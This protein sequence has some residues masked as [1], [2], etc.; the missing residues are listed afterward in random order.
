MTLSAAAREYLLAFADDE[1]LIGAR[2]TNW[3]GLGPFLEEDLAFCS[4]AQ[5][6]LGHAVALYGLLLDD[7]AQLDAFAMIRDPVRLP[8]LLA[9]R[10]RMPRLE[11]LARPPLAVRPRRG[12]PLGR[13]RRVSRRRRQRDR[14]TRAQREESF[15]LAHA[16]QFMSRIAAA[17]TTGRIVDSIGHLVP[18]AAGLWDATRSEPA[19]SR[20][21]SG[22]RLVSW[23]TPGSTSSAPISTG[24]ASTSTG[25]DRRARPT[26]GP[27]SAIARS[28]AS[29]SPSSRPTC[30]GSS[31]STRPPCGS[32]AEHASHHPINQPHE[33]DPDAN[34][35]RILQ[36]QR[37]AAVHADRPDQ[38]RDNASTCHSTGWRSNHWGES[39]R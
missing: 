1:H 12:A 10:D 30:F 39:V 5:D 23:L 37:H 27:P 26:S 11:R 6:E 15:H 9:G 33:Q 4:I 29:R 7:P 18:L 22:R 13:P 3:I 35:D 32:P 28:A 24:G 38:N 19:Q 17:D 20:A 25:H 16:E 36:D 2:H 31:C 8:Q 34:P 21:S 14:R